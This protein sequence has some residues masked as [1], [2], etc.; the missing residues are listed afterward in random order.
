MDQPF[1]DDVIEVDLSSLQ[2]PEDPFESLISRCMNLLFEG[3]F[4]DLLSALD[5]SA[6]LLASLEYTM[7]LGVLLGAASYRP[8]VTVN[9]FDAVLSVSPGAALFQDAGNRTPLHMVLMYLD[10]P[11]LVR[12]LVNASPE[13]VNMADMEGLRP[14]DI[15][16]RK[17]LMKE[18]SSD[19]QRVVDGMGAKH[20]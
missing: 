3:R 13:C 4:D 5:E 9:I 12:A 6:E 14:I 15:L 20:T 18:G 7:Q 8:S 2:P 19:I 11:D 16:T 10:R 17:I 1:Y